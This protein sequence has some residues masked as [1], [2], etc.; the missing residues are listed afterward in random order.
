MCTFKKQRREQ[1]PCI[2]C[3]LQQ[4]YCIKE[5]LIHHTTWTEVKSRWVTIH[6]QLWTP[7]PALL[8]LFLKSQAGLSVSG[9]HS[10][11]NLDVTST[12]Q[13]TELSLLLGW[14]KIKEKV[15][16]I[17]LWIIKYGALPNCTRDKWGRNPLVKIPRPHNTLAKFQNDTGGKDAL[18]QV[19]PLT[20][21]S[22]VEGVLE[23]RGLRRCVWH[24]RANCPAAGRATAAP[25]TS[26]KEQDVALFCHTMNR[27]WGQKIWIARPSKCFTRR[28][29]RF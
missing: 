29:E 9:C 19:L 13:K 24:L 26:H 18:T 16:F 22:L 21:L 3:S 27:W 14:N 25:E 12:S 10:H 4:G 20:Q 23:E 7:Q 8:D 6:P 15:W 28:Y 17:L 1:G 11:K 5:I 2:K